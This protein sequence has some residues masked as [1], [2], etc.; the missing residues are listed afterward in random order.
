MHHRRKCL[1]LY[2]PPLFTPH[3]L[4]TP[5]SN[6]IFSWLLQSLLCSFYPHPSCLNISCNIWYHRGP[7]TSPVCVWERQRKCVCV[8]WTHFSLVQFCSCRNFKRKRKEKNYCSSRL[9]TNHSTLGLII[10]SQNKQIWWWHLVLMLMTLNGHSGSWDGVLITPC[11][12]EKIVVEL[13]AEK[14]EDLTFTGNKAAHLILIRCR[15]S[16]PECELLHWTGKNN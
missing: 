9:P 3:C 13:P 4:P 2:S 6:V 11:D 10:T 12:K 1:C 8:K 5:N 7:G 16:G 15:M 14:K